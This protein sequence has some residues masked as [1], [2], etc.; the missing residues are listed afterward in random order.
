M[1]L[2]KA[3]HRVTD[4]AFCDR[5]RCRHDE[6]ADGRIGKVTDVLDALPELVEH[7]DAAAEQRAAIQRRLHAE[8]A[9]VEQPDAER[10]LEIGN[11]A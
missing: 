7:R 1:A 3:A 2:R 5:D 6:L 9:A 10:M 4:K 8:R 11:R